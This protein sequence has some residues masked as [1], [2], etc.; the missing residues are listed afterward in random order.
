MPPVHAC[1]GETERGVGARVYRVVRLVRADAR[2]SVQDFQGAFGPHSDEI[3]G[4][5]PNFTRIQ[6]V[7]QISE[8]KL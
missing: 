2:G 1:R 6:P 3:M 4:D 5:I 8:I 7:V